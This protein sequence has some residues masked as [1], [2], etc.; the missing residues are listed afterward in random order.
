LDSADAAAEVTLATVPAAA[1]N[2]Q[3]VA[4]AFTVVSPAP[5]KAPSMPSAAHAAG[6][7][8]LLKVSATA[9]TAMAMKA[10]APIAPLVAAACASQLCALEVGLS[11]TSNG[12][13]SERK[14]GR[15]ARKLSGP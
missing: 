13:V 8:P 14:R 7:N 6:R 3:S 5:R 11:W 15:A 4:I 10:I 9:T 12:S 1:Q 2:S